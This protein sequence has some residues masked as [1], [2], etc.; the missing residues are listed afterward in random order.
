VSSISL[1]FA[2]IITSNLPFSKWDSIFKDKMTTNAAIDRLVHHATILELNAPS[3][4]TK[5][6]KNKKKMKKET[7]NAKETVAE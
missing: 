7:S 3:Y 4:R 6:A 2:L 5:S 1:S